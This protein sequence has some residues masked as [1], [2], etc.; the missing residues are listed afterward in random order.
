[1]HNPGLSCAGGFWIR[2]IDQRIWLAL[3]KWSGPLL[4]LP[5]ALGLP[6]LMT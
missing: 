1:M 4:N 6:I 3:Q 2:H 5:P